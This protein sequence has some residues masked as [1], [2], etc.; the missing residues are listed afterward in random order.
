[1]QGRNPCAFLQYQLLLVDKRRADN[2]IRLFLGA[3]PLAL[4]S[5]PALDGLP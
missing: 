1:M 2:M 3:I 5:P 4:V